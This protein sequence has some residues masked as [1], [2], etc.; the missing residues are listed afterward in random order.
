ML[1]GCSWGIAG[2]VQ[3]GGDVVVSLGGD[4]GVILECH[5]SD[6]GDVGASLGRG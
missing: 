6:M 1:G 5:C 3:Q 4:T 2:E